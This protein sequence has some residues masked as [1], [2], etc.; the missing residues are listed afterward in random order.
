VIVGLV[1]AVIE[2]ILVIIYFILILT[3]LI[4]Y[5]L[6][7][8]RRRPD[9]LPRSQQEMQERGSERSSV[10]LAEEEGRAR[11]AGKGRNESSQF[12]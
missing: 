7:A 5:L 10:T 11:N 2:A 8:F 1:I 6:L 9:D 4:S 12:A 3:D